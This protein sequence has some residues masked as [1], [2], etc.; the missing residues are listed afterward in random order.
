MESMFEA[1]ARTA[2]APEKPTVMSQT[3]TLDERVSQVE[4]DLAKL[5]SQVDCLRPRQDQIEQI[6]DFAAGEPAAVAL[7]HRVN[8]SLSGA[9]MF[10]D[11]PLF[12]EWRR[13]IAEYRR[14]VD[15]IADAP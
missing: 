3:P 12:D 1:A 9:R 4:Q 10:R 13:A 6:A 15:G 11:D 5:K 2:E 8:P 7:P 14:E